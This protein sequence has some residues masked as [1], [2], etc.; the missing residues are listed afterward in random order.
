MN[1][2]TR[3]V[4]E[5]LGRGYSRRQIADELGVSSPRVTQ[6]IGAAPQLSPDGG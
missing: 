3:R 1:E 4:A 2:Q 6:I 5:L